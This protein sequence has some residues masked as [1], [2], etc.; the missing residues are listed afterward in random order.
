MKKYMK[1]IISVAIG[2]VIVGIIAIW[3]GSSMIARQANL[4]SATTYEDAYPISEIKS[5]T[6]DCD[7]LNIKAYDVDGD[8]LTLSWIETK[9]I[10]FKTVNNNGELSITYHNELRWVDHLIPRIVDESLYTLVIGVPADYSGSLSLMSISGEVIVENISA[11]ADIHLSA[12]SGSLELNNIDSG[13]DITL[14]ISSGRLKAS[15]MSSEGSIA[16]RA[17]SGKIEANQIAL[18][19]DFSAKGGSGWIEISALRGA[20]TADLL[21]TSGRMTFSEIAVDA[22]TAKTGSGKMRF[23]N[24]VAKKSISLRAG[25]GDIDGSIKDSAGKFTIN[26]STFS[27]KNNLPD[28]ISIGEKTL[29]VETGSGDID[30]IFLD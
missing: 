19:G 9:D 1:L 30:I 3:A 23:D 8:E 12:G 5:I 27:G 22:L 10:H 17:G 7:S 2:I 20:S 21:T 14:S 16:I 28:N 15:N 18:N 13:S 25:S 24:I 6:A 26:T 4:S 29:T 11:G